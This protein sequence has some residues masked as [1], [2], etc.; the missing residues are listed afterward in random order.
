MNTIAIILSIIAIGFS[1]YTYLTKYWQQNKLN[2]KLKTIQDLSNELVSKVPENLAIRLQSVESLLDKSFAGILGLVKVIT[3]N[4]KNYLQK[5]LDDAVFNKDYT[6]K[7]SVIANTLTNNLVSISGVKVTNNSITIFIPFGKLY[8]NSE[9]GEYRQEEEFAK[10]DL[11][12]L[13]GNTSI[14]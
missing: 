1:G 10:F 14:A 12:F 13:K 8:I 4:N 9:N 6:D 11:S 7:V 2:T 5:M 3:T